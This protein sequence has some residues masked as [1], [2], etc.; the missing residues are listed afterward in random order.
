MCVLPTQRLGDFAKKG[1]G[2]YEDD[3][4]TVPASLAGLPALSLPCGQD[5]AGLPIGLQLIGAMGCVTAVQYHER[6]AGLVTFDEAR[7]YL[8]R[9]KLSSR[10]D[11]VRYYSQRL[12][13]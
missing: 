6:L 11:G 9:R 5:R 1:V 8:Y 3:V 10:Y 12:A 13:S 2:A 4:F 7:P